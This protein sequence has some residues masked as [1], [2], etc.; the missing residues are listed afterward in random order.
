[1][2]A[3]V[4]IVILAACPQLRPGFDADSPVNTRDIIIICM[5]AVACLMMVLCGTSTDAI[6]LASTFRSGVSSLAVIL[7]IVTLGTTFIDAYLAKIRG[8][9]GDIL[10]AYPVLLALV[11]F[12][13]Y[14]LLYSQSTTTPLIIPLAIA[15]GAPI[16]TILASYVAV[17]KVFV[18]PTYPTSL[19]AMEFD[20]AGTTRVD[21]YILSHPFTLPRLGGVI[22]DVAFGSIIAPMVA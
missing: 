3:T 14:A 5:L 9:A 22:A 13:T 12:G 16:W 17:T 6:V 1:M 20:T 11:L 10:R 7:G 18:L 15:L 8:I 2:L 21:K 4:I 19:A